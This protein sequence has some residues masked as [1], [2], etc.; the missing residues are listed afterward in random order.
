[1]VEI[2]D[3]RNIVKAEQEWDSSIEFGDASNLHSL[4]EALLSAADNIDN[5]LEQIY[6]AQH[7]N[8]AGRKEL[9]QYGKLINLPPKNEEDIEKYRARIKAKFAQSNTTTDFNSFV[10]FCSSILETEESNISF[11]TEY[12]GNPA[13]VTVAADGK[14]YEEAS[15]T[16]VEIADVFSGGV[17]AGHTVNVLE[18]GTFRLKSDSAINDPDKGLTSDS[19]NTGGTLSADL[20]E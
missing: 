8:T 14:L 4:V 17:P 18:N 20:V 10:Q 2:E 6:D 3:N 13:T 9:E 7:I 5:E 16:P 11:V 15:L 19:I 1:M 12:A